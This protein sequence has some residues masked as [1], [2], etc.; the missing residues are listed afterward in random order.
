M[1]KMQ[2]LWNILLFEDARIVLYE[3][4]LLDCLSNPNIVSPVCCGGGQ[5]LQPLWGGP[6]WVHPHSAYLHSMQTTDITY[7]FNCFHLTLFFKSNWEAWNYIVYG[8]REQICH[9]IYS[10]YSVSTNFC[11]KLI[12]PSAREIGCQQLFWAL[13]TLFQVLLGLS[14]V[15][16]RSPA[17]LSRPESKDKIPH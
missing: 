7:V 15:L 10:S 6:G 9:G 17:L 5:A 1:I 3:D 4:F 2:G 14:H 13:L 11:L 8:V 12:K 16:T